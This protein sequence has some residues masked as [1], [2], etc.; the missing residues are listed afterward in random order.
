M[1][2]AGSGSDAILSQPAVAALLFQSGV[3]NPGCVMR[4]NLAMTGNLVPA[5]T[6]TYLPAMQLLS[7]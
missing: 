1:A 4:S 6:C 7:L 3:N 5:C 2:I